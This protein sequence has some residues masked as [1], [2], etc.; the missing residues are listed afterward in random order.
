M[1]KSVSKNQAQDVDLSTPFWEFPKTY[2][3]GQQRIL[4]E[5]FYSLLGVSEDRYVAHIV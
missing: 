2:K 5:T 3:L 4:L 1:S